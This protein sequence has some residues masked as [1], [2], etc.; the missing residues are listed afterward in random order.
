[1]AFD[2]VH[3]EVHMPAHY[4]LPGH[5]GVECIDV[6]EALELDLLLGSAFQYL[7]RAGRKS[8]SEKTI[9]DLKK[10]VWYI[11]RKIYK[12]ELDALRTKA[13]CEFVLY[14]VPGDPVVRC[15]HVKGHDGLHSWDTP[16]K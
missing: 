15:L 5:P 14:P 4:Q 11:N 9:V 6:C 7:W 8:T 2:E 16:D 10:A 13:T 1:M 3:D 12:L